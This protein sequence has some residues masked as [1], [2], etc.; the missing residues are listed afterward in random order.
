MES[1]PAHDRGEAG[2]R[3]IPYRTTLATQGQGGPHEPEDTDEVRR[4]HH[5]GGRAPPVGVRCPGAD[6]APAGPAPERADPPRQ[7]HAVRG[8]ASPPGPARPGP[9]VAGTARHG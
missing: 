5:P 3:L 8:P 6:V 2:C 1:S 9:P 4:A 7:S